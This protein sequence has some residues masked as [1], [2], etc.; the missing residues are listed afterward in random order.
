M[1]DGTDF[2]CDVA[3]PRTRQL[4]VVHE[5]DE[6]LAFHHTRP[7]WEQHL[8]VVPKRHIASFTTIGMSDEAVVREL[9]AVVQRVARQVEEEYGEAAVLTNLGRYQDSKHLHVARARRTSARQQHHHLVVPRLREHVHQHRLHRPQRRH[10]RE[11]ARQGLGV[12]ARVDDV[13]DV[14]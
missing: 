10:Q 5:S 4:T 2:Y 7:F 1:Y 8:V 12:A 11:V 14:R 3:I 9:F 13:P 6:V